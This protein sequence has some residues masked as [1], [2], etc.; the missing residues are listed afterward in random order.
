[1]DAWDRLQP[2]DA[3]IDTIARALVKLKETDE[4]SRGIG[5][6]YVATFL[7]GAR[8]RDAEE[9]DVPE[10]NQSTKDGWADDEE[11]L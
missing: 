5:I 10:K 9:V 11:V 4:W 8:W 6:P 2:D 1:M 7:R 3:L